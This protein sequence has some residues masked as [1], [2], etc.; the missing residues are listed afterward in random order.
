MLSLR[1]A[2]A[3]AERKPETV[4][5]WVAAG[6]LTRHTGPIPRTGGAAPL[7]VDRDELLAHLAASGQ[8]P[9]PQG[10]EG[11]PVPAD[12]LG[13]H[14][15]AHPP[16]SPG[17]GHVDMRVQMEA[18][19]GQVEIER[20]RGR[21]ATAQ[22]EREALRA[23]LDQVLD[24]VADLQRQ[25]LALRQDLEEAR[26]ESRAYRAELQALR[27]RQGLSLWQRLIGRPASPPELP[28]SS[29]EPL[30]AK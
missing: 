16:G 14:L 11:V 24:L 15:D 12:H 10:S 7:L 19:R 23:Q 3:V 21:V 22:A 28:D 4:R 17:I 6:K 27:A 29:W 25:R 18:L 5:K 30:E 9:R 1:E 2:G 20:L 8:R 26:D 13:S